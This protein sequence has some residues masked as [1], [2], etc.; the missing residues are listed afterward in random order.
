MRKPDFFIV[1]A[2]KCGTTAM[3]DYLKQHPE[4]FMP[5][6]KELNFWGQDLT[7]RFGRIKKDEYLSL[8]REVRNEK[9][10]GEVCI[11]SLYSTSAP[12]EIKDFSPSAKIIIMLRNP[13]EMIYALHSQFLYDG[14]EDIEKFKDALEAEED[15]KRRLRIPNGCQVVEGLFY[16]EVPKFSVQVRRY[17]DV[18]GRDNVHIIIFDDFKANTPRVY[19][20]TLR[21]LGVD[22]SFKPE[23]KVINPNKVV[24]SKALREF[25]H[26]P[27]PMA[28]KMG[29]YLIPKPLRQQ[30]I[31]GLQRINTKHVPRPPM[32]PELRRQLQ[33]E[34]KPEVEKLS[35][36][37]GRDLTY[38]VK[39]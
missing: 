5:R 22:D 20:N 38:W 7:F 9:R 37:L 35:E 10:V 3:Y 27:S 31:K 18:F 8:F 30:I 15:R 32:D 1:G 24:R 26:D 13:I 14:H 23:F 36:L 28:R 6:I 39:E 33:E 11:W 2:P 19:K 25:I 34:F 12:F 21:F 29:K 17:F 16:R 4:I